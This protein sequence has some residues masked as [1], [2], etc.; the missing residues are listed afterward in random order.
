MSRA[1]L[2]CPGRGSYT[3]RSLRSLPEAHPFV[4]RA[5]ELRAEYGLVSLSELDRAE[6][7]SPSQHLLPANVSALIYLVSM[8]DAQTAQAEHEIVCAG[9]NSLGWYTALAV[10]GALSFDDGFRLVQEMSVLQQELAKTGGQI[11]F[12]LVGDDWTLQPGMVESVRSALATSNGQAFPSIDLGGSLALA[13]SD[14]GIAHL[15]R[16]LM[17]VKRGSII[18]PLRLVQHGPYHTPLV[19]EVQRRARES[20][21]R[22]EFRP[23]RVTLIDGRGNRFTPWSCDVDALAEYTLGAQIVEPFSF[24]KSVLVALHEHAPDRI[25]L[26]GPGNTLGGVCGQ[27]LALDG[28]RGI[29]TKADFERLQASENPVVVSMRR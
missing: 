21:A 12:P 23:P 13:G 1:A 17:P 28:W 8:L 11:L 7:F 4:E 14:E 18:Y 19:A 6:R 25:V 22:L 3:E 26:P 24:H 2:F 16:S 29:H 9:G 20:L 15:L 27:I 5:N 10:G